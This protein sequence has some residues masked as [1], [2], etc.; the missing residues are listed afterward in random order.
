MSSFSSFFIE[1]FILISEIKRFVPIYSRFKLCTL[2]HFISLRFF[3]YGTSYLLENFDL[4][5]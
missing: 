1:K 3:M 4:K 5:L 2:V